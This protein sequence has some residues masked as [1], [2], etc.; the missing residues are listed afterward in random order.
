ME[1]VAINYTLRKPLVGGV[2]L[3]LEFATLSF[4]WKVAPALAAGTWWWPNP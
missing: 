2:Y 3:A 1:G 4:T